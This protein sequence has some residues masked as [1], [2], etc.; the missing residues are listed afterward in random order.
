MHNDIYFSH[1][2]Q[3]QVGE[4][5]PLRVSQSPGYA[6]ITGQ[7]HHRDRER[8]VEGTAALHGVGPEVTLHLHSPL[9]WATLIPWSQ[10][11]RKTGKC[12]GAHGYG[13]TCFCHTA[14]CIFSMSCD[15][16]TQ[17]L[18]VVHFL[19]AALSQGLNCTTLLR[20]LETHLC[21][22]HTQWLRGLL[23]TMGR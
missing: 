3:G 21:T 15:C 10:F 8:R 2:S 1:P 20:P 11:A 7:C 19:A 9:Y 22:A 18:V 14:N 23:G 4:G 6:A 13:V 17:S 16:N 12:R 5:F